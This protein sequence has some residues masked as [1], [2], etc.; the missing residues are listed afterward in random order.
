[1]D[2]ALTVVLCVTSV[3]VVVSLDQLPPFLHK[4]MT[5]KTYEYHWQTLNQNKP[6]QNCP[7]IIFNCRDLFSFNLF[8]SCSAA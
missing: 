4:F 3:G 7:N 2:V 5:A 8:S 6:H 1:M